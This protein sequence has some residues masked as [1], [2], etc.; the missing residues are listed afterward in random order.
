MVNL[1]KKSENI[2]NCEKI[3]K[4]TGRANLFDVEADD[5][6]ELIHDKRI[7]ETRDL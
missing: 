2:K 7:I 1:K 6:G 4:E 5:V 3:N